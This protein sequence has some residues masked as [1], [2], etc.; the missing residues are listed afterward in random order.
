[1]MANRVEFIVAVYAISKL[2][3]AAVL[4]SPAW[5]RPRSVTPST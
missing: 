5:K 2:G 3:A 4:V 1:M